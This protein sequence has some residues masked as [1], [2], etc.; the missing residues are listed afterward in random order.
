MHLLWRRLGSWEE[1]GELETLFLPK[2]SDR[3]A[4][5]RIDVTDIAGQLLHLFR[6][7][8]SPHVADALKLSSFLHHHDGR[9]HFTDENRRFQELD[10]FCCRDHGLDAPA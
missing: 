2:Q 1:C 4:T 8:S 9:M 7:S 5:I 6:P 3:S 10:A